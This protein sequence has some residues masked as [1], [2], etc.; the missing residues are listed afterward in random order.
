MDTKDFMHYMCERWRRGLSVPQEIK[1]FFERHKSTAM[2]SD[3]RSLSDIY[4][5][6]LTNRSKATAKDRQRDSGLRPLHFFDDYDVARYFYP[7]G[8][9]PPKTP[10]KWLMPKDV[11]RVIMNGRSL[12]VELTDGKKGVAHCDGKDLYDPYVGFCI[13]YFNA[14][15]GG[16]HR[17]K[18][19]LTV[20]IDR[21]HKKSYKNAILNNREV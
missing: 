6:E 4:E 12:V 2:G 8:E 16:K 10:K 14:H 5:Y 7:Y 21:A 11:K 20:C 15:N 19:A 17:L 1:G 3:Y 13:A 9:L 18:K